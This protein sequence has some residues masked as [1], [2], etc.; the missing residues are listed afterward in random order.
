MY[1]YTKIKTVRYILKIKDEDIQV[2]FQNGKSVALFGTKVNVHLLIIKTV[3]IDRWSIFQTC[4]CKTSESLYQSYM[5]LTEARKAENLSHM[6][7][8]Y[9][10]Q[11]TH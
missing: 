7:K 8:P 9:F 11:S 10:L 1:L 6:A 4:S 2:I 5:C 3:R